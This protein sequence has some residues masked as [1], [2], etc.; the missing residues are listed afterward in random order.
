MQPRIL[1]P[2]GYGL[3]CEAETAYSFNVV[4]GEADTIHL[5]RV[6]ANPSILEKYQILAMIGGFSFGDHIAAGKVLANRYKYRLAEHLER[7]VAEG[8][9][10][11]GICNGF[12]SMVQYGLL[13]G[14]DGNFEEQ[15]VSLAPNDSG[16]FE[17][18][19]VTLAVNKNSKCVFIKDIDVLELPVRHGEGKFVTRDPNVLRRLWVQGQV[20]IQYIDPATGMPTMKYPLNPNGSIDAI[21]GICDPTGRIFGLMPHPEA[22]NSPYNHPN[23]PSQI[24]VNRLPTEGLGLQIFRNAVEYVKNN[25]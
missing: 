12:Q 15:L 5:S 21:A 20:V 3:N 4:G 9:L 8:K 25:F 14:F 19:W 11:L 23:W 17:D 6:F 18:R 13:P 22:Y 1:V 2:T 16:V 10:I 7:F 24:L